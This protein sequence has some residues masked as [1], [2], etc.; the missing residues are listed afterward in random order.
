MRLRN[1]IIFLKSFKKHSLYMQATPDDDLWKVRQR[2]RKFW[3]IH[4]IPTWN[5]V[6]Y[7]ETWKDL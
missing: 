2:S 4:P 6:I 5:Q 3:Q 1:F 7:Q